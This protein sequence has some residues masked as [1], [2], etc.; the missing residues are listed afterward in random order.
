MKAQTD[1]LS[2]FAEFARD[3]VVQTQT[4]ED[5]ERRARKAKRYEMQVLSEFE[6]LK[7]VIMVEH[8]RGRRQKVV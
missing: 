3:V 6:K 2:G 4:V 8:L 5:A 1:G 7:T